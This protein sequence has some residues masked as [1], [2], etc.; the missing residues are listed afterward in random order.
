MIEAVLL[1]QSTASYFAILNNASMIR[2]FI[3]AEALFVNVIATMP[4][5]L[6][7]VSGA[8]SMDRY[9]N[10]SWKVLPLPAEAFRIHSGNIFLSIDT[11]TLYDDFCRLKNRKIR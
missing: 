4:L 10:T 11:S 3:S 8:K 1:S 6:F 2:V 7:G 5:Y 9:S